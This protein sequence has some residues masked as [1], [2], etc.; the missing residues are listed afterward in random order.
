MDFPVAGKNPELVPLNSGR[1]SLFK[2]I[3]ETSAVSCRAGIVMA[4]AG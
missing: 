4:E 3:D 2:T 1:L